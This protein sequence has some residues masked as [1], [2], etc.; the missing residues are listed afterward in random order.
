MGKKFVASYSGGKDSILA[1]H[2]AMIQ[3]YEPI[4][5]ITTYD[6]KNSH[7]WFHNVPKK[8]LMQTSESMDIPLK[9]IETGGEQYA[10][11]FEK[12][13]ME[14]KAMGAEICVFGDIDIQDHFDWCD[15]RC[16][17]A[18]IESYFPLWQNDRK[19]I[20]SEFIENGFKAVVTVLDTTRMN[21][22][23]LG[24]TLSNELVENLIK[25]GADV[26]G[27]N[28]EY[29]TFAFDGPIFKFPIILSLGEVIRD[30]KYVRLPIL[31]K[32][33]L[34]QILHGIEPLNEETKKLAK[35]RQDTLIKPIGSL[36]KIEDLS[37]Q[38]AGI[39]GNV[40]GNFSKK[41]IIIMCADNGV[42]TEGVSAAPQIVTL[43]QATNFKKNITGVGVLSKLSDSD[44]VV[45]DI[46]INSDVTSENFENH[47]IRKGTNNIAEKYA[48]SREEAL[49]AIDVGFRQ[50]EK[51]YQAGYKVIGTGEM[52]IGNTTTSSLIIMS[53]TG[54]SI[55]E[56]VGRGAGL[57]DESFSNKKTL[58][59]KIL[60]LHKPN[61]SDP[62][63][64]LSKVGGLDI[65][66]LVGV[67]LGAAH[68][69][70][71]VVI[72]G[73][74]SATS[75]LLAYRLCERA[76]DYMIASHISEE[77]G[78]SVAIEALGIKPY[79][80]LSMRLGEG[81][82]CPFT[83]F[84]IDAAEKII[85]EMSTFDEVSMDNSTLVDIRESTTE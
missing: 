50:V 14:F 58:I 10:P 21:E 3:G 31:T 76:K 26:C 36:G 62:I 35:E 4:G 30:Q 1:I 46:G 24:Q 44:M 37:I 84:L 39:T 85:K 23:Y 29:H 11:D 52:G 71:P 27:E 18:G 22:K 56:A 65:A 70:I 51:L 55:D 79:F 5:L 9:I 28:G 42:C 53:L 60:D 25:D 12:V 32:M 59:K 68:Y 77:P 19:S 17:N 7:S 49:Q 75:A 69:K 47:K 16:K 80:D 2:R 78:Y 73:I 45:I 48:M 82:G 33:N 15:T 61:A 6:K 74:I 38:L 40:Y 54:C 34:D 57:T 72:D 43:M 64:V 8:I 66:G 67:F 83:F 81:S 13:L 41:A 63:D 20:V